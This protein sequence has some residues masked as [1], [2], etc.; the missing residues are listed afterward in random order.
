MAIIKK[1]FPEPP[2][3][4]QIA[5]GTVIEGSITFS[6]ELRIDGWVKGPVTSKNRRHDTLILGPHGRVDGKVDSRLVRLFEVSEI[7]R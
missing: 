4:S 7:W 1:L 5:E 2:V 6:G 3:L